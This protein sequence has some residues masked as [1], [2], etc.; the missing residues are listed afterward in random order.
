[1]MDVRIKLVFNL[2]HPVYFK[3]Y[4]T[5]LQLTQYLPYNQCWDISRHVLET[6]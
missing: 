2:Q 1:M 5:I 3:I 4:N 6:C